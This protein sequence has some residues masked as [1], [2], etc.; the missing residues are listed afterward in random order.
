MLLGPM[1][2][3]KIAHLPPSPNFNTNRKPNSDPEQGGGNSPQAQLSERLK[4]G[5]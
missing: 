3:M 2:L 4:T 1:L 5:R